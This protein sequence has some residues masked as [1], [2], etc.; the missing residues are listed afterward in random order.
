MQHISGSHASAAHLIGGAA[1]G[2]AAAHTSWAVQKYG[3]ARAWSKSVARKGSFAAPLDPR[4]I[5]AGLLHFWCIWGERIANANMQDEGE[6]H[7][8]MADWVSVGSRCSRNLNRFSLK[9]LRSTAG[10]IK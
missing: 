8:S 5:Y 2:A 6:R 10:I 1:L 4:R 9:M 7:E 3:L